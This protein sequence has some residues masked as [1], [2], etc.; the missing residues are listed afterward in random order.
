[1]CKILSLA[2]IAFLFA[3]AVAAAGEPAIPAGDC[4]ILFLG[5]SNTYGG[6][7]IEFVDALLR[8]ENPQ[9]HRQLL[10]LGLPSETVS[11]LSEPGHAGGQF[12][13]PDLAERLERVLEKTRPGLIVA[14]YGMNDGIYYPPSPERLKKYQDGILHLRQRAAAMHAKV[15]HLTPP[16]F[17]RVP[18]QAKTLPAGLAEYPQPYEG[19]DDVLEQFSAWLLAQKSLGWDVVDVHGPMKL[20]LAAQR[21]QDPNFRLAG[22]GV[23]IDATGHWIIA[24]QLLRHW[25]A[26][27]TA[28]SEAGSG[29]QAVSAYPHGAD[30][31]KLIAEKQRLLKDA[32][33]TATGH[34][35]PGMKA[36]LPIDEAEQR[37]A[38]LDSEI[39]KLLEPAK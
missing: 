21:A 13:R 25:A 37:A 22:D 39:D 10:N 16:V 14:C 20:F 3:T 8:L 7:Y 4:R 17:D 33:L 5:D 1:M 36:G 6:Q 23:H 19:Y 32:W 26:L 11:G 2:A 12:P 28:A 34:K 24:Q 31:L 30:V 15:L 18:I 27:S 29:Q 35:R 38:A 9:V